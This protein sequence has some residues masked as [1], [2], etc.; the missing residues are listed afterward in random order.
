MNIATI[1]QKHATTRPQQEAIIDTYRQQKRTTTFAELEK[2]AGLAASLLRQK[3]LKAGDAVLVFYPMSAELYI[4]LAALF[5]LGLI[6]MFLDPSVSKDHIN[7]CCTLYSPKALIASSK[8]NLLRLQSSALRRIPLKIAIG[9]PVPGAVSWK[10]IQNLTLDEEI[11]PCTPDTSALLTFT[12]GST[13]KPKAALRTHGFLLAQ[14]K[15]LVSTLQ[16]QP[17]HTSLT[18]LPI[19]VLANL[20]SG[21]TS[22]IPNVDLKRPGAIKPKN[23]IAEIKTHK[24]QRAVASPAFFERITEYCQKH[25]LTLSSLE[26]IFLGGAPVMPRTVTQLQKIAPNAEITIVYGS[27]EAEPIAHIS[28]AHISDKN[29]QSEDFAPTLAGNGLLVGKPVPEIQLRILPD[30][31][32][33][34][35]E[36]YTNKEFIAACLPKN[37]PGEIVVSGEHVL[38]SYLYGY[39]NEETKFTVNNTSWHRTGDAGYIDEQGNLW[40]LGRCIGCINDSNGSLYPLA[41]EGIIQNYP[42]IHRS[43]IILHNQ[44]RILVVELNEANSPIDWIPIQESLAKMHITKIKICKK[45]PVDKRHNGKIDYPALQNL[46]HTT[47]TIM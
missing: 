36:P 22:L 24:P 6:A 13:G 10:Q 19:F 17:N 40:L 14:H 9:C 47:K 37:T 42:G 4:T 43:A 25:D 20:A 38:P 16:L 27:T 30:R 32:G 41:V 21:L 8:A 18:T 1:L 34:P 7:N 45:I 12:S 39:G 15:A 46:L 23:A 28:Y 5:R 31:W 44:E 33:E 3:G 29:T 35:I 26:K 2:L 11:H